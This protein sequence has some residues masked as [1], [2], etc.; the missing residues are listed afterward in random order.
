M[1]PRLLLLLALPVVLFLAVLGVVL[2]V[3]D[4]DGETVA[5]APSSI[6]VNVNAQVTPS[7]LPPSATPAPSVTPIVRESCAAIRGTQYESEAERAWFRTNCPDP[8]P[9]PRQVISA[10]TSPSSNIYG[11]ADRFV[12]TRLGINAPVNVSV[13]GPDGTMGNPVGGSDVVL[14]DFSGVPG[15]G[16]YPPAGG[17][18]V[19]AGHV[20]YICCPAV[21]AQLR[22]VREGDVI[23]YYTG[24]GG[25]YQ[26]VVQWFGDYPPETNWASLVS[27]GPNIMTLIT[28]NGT[29]DTRLREYSHRR[30]VR[31][32]LVAQSDGV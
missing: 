28:C 3:N 21:F 7:P 25:H 5:A 12:I 19:I 11:T 10:P 26:Y 2:A 20:D 29:F 13:V 18:T 32:T 16:G 27:G 15:L 9:A 1:K 8:T 6:A 30:V 31:A 14:Y 4:D 17:N 23:D 22:N 24:D